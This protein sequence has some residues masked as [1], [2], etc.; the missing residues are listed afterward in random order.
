MN[1]GEMA[2]GREDQ[3]ALG[4]SPN[5]NDFLPSGAVTPATTKSQIAHATGLG[6]RA[7]GITCK[8]LPRLPA[9]RRSS[10][11]LS[12]P[13]IK[14]HPPQRKPELHINL[15]VRSAASDR[16]WNDQGACSVGHWL[17]P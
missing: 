13:E 12:G 15:D 10:G 16:E 7:L 1:L 2:T 4:V 6:R 11:S 5:S 9:T 17:P 8:W 14:V 3:D